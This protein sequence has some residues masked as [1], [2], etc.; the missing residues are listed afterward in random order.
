[1]AL[2]L[3]DNAVAAAAAAAASPV[4]SLV[5]AV[6][7]GGVDDACCGLA[8]VEAYVAVEVGVKAM[9]VA[10]MALFAGV[11]D[12]DVVGVTVAVF[13]PQAAGAGATTGAAATA[14][15]DAGAPATPFVLFCTGAALPCCCCPHAVVTGAGRQAE[16]EKAAGT[17]GVTEPFAVD[18]TAAPFQPPVP[19]PRGGNATCAGSPKG[20]SL[21]SPG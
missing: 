11:V 14:A 17:V 1:M 15:G 12:V 18:V 5:E 20:V 8:A 19:G 21:S 10:A 4:L 7:L 13:C 16:P 3:R 2:T 6:V 9:V